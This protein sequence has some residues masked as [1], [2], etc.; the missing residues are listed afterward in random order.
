MTF[1]PAASPPATVALQSSRETV[2]QE[3]LSLRQKEPFERSLGRVVRR[4]GGD[5]AD[6]LAII[7]DVREHARAK[8]M[9]LREAARALLNA[10]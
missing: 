9:D 3:A 10:R 7:A 2:L 4:H 6:Y 5:Y 8:R 1:Y